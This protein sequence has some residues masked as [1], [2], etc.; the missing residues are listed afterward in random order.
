MLMLVG[1][2]TRGT[3]SRGIYGFDVDLASGEITGTSITSDIDNPSYLIR[4]PRLDVVYTVNEVRDFVGEDGA[5]SAF[6][7]DTE[8]NLELINQVCSLGSD[9]CHLEISS[10][11][12]FLFVS[13]YSSGTLAAFPLDESGALQEF[14]SFVQHTGHSV[15]P[16]R[17]KAPHVH[18]V[19]LGKHERFAYVA[20]LGLDRL[21]WY[22][23][24]S[25]GQLRAGERKTVRLRTGSGPR[26]FCFDGKYEYC[27]VINELD[28]TIT[29]IG[30]DTDGSLMEISTV[31]SLPSGYSDASYCGEIQLS[32]D[33]RF[34]YASNRGH[35]SLVVFKIRPQGSLDLVQHIPSGGQ[36]PR[37][38]RIT[39]D[40]SHLVVANRDTDNILAFSVD[41][42]SGELAVTGEA[43]SVPAPVC[44]LFPQPG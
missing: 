25:S 3:G 38:F 42:A 18:S 11:G 12:K 15:D 35:D 20:D 28:N 30:V 19:K 37:H 22:P 5:V 33:G 24:D 13:N 43:V 36:H 9:P 1:T 23:L 14:V 8:G 21:I 31:D 40:G 44:I 6:H 4:H 16:M 27:Y 41:Q 10:A 26:H 34:L 29:S 7:L 17:Q 39:P 32:K 2:Y